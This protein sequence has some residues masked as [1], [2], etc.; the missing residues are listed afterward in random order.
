VPPSSACQ[1]TCGL[2]RSVRQQN[3]LQRRRL[4]MARKQVAI[5]QRQSATRSVPQ[6]NQKSFCPTPPPCNLW[7]RI[8]PIPVFGAHAFGDTEC[9]M[10]QPVENSAGGGL[11]QAIGIG[12]PR[13]W[14]ST[15]GS[16]TTIESS[17]RNATRTDGAPLER[18]CVDITVLKF[19]SRQLV[20]S[21]QEFKNGSFVS[22][23][24]PSRFSV[25]T[26]TRLQVETISPSRTIS[27]ST[28]DAAR[29]RSIIRQRQ[30]SRTAS[31][32]DCD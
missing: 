4:R 15:C 11:P 1:R 27:P 24:D 9:V 21:R 17:E 14:P 7:I 25:N 13:T 12:T 31:G 6:R 32:V 19:R 18:Q 20:C 10:D 16:P 8:S 22:S 30:S 29:W 26:S 28:N 23:A 5:S 3:I 2:F